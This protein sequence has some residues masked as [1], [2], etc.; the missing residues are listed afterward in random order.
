MK[1]TFTLELL[2]EHELVNIYSI[3]QSGET[4]TKFEQFI[5]KY[6][7]PNPNDV[8]VIMY[9]IDRIIKDGVF[10]RHFRYAS[11]MNDHVFELPSSIDTSKLR[12]YCLCLSEEILVLGEGGL[13]QTRT[14]NEDAVLNN[15]VSVL[16][17]IDLLI[18]ERI[19][20]KAI[21]IT[22]K[23]IAGNLN[24]SIEI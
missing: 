14:Y 2:E 20:T 4:L 15:Y 21:Q 5:E 18:K 8:G 17:K 22:G 11:K 23:T 12:V 10:E 13:K 6:A 16:Q 3:K 9:R 24:F 7:I 19:K 1:R